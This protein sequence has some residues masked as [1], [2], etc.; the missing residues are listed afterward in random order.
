VPELTAS[1]PAQLLT[2][3]WKLTASQNNDAAAGGLTLTGWN[4]GAPQRAGMW[5]EIDM[6]GTHRVTEIQFQSPVP[7]GTGAAVSP[8][9]AVVQPQNVS[10]YGFPRGFKVE[11]STDGVSW[12]TVAEAAA[13]GP[14]TVVTFPPAAASRIRLTLTADADTPPPWSLQDLRVFAQR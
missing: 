4:A 10:G 12:K 13:R 1:L 9:G 2:D 3:G 8:Q 5:F 7:G 11:I 14:N 6:P